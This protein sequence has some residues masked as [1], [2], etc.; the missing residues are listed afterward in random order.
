MSITKIRPKHSTK[1][2]TA[3][4]AMTIVT[5][6]V[7]STNFKKKE[8]AV[9]RPTVANKAAITNCSNILLALTQD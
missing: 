4:I 8:V 2:T 7:V 5:I 1:A 3:T 9:K 6:Q